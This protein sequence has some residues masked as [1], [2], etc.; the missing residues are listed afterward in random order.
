M[1]QIHY[2]AKRHIVNLVN[3]EF[4]KNLILLRNIIEKNCDSYFQAL[5]APK[6][7]L[8]MISRAVSSPMGKGSDSLPIEIKFGNE[9]AYLVDSAQFGMEPL[10]QKNFEIVYCYLPSFRG[11][12]PD[13]C[14]LNQFYHCEAEI[15]GDYK[16]SMLIA[17]NLIKH[18]I[19]EIITG[20]EKKVFDFEKH[21]FVEIENLITNPFPVI[22][23]DEA[24]KILSKNN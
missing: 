2:N 21:N 18:L 1:K 17:E 12:T 11:E 19:K 8:Y 5:G 13:Y 10:V 7:D 4:Y 20:Y 9:N 23:F 24:E 15:Q 6:I 14:H 22:S 16:K 3:D